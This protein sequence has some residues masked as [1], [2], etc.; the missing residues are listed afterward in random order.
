M[1]NARYP[2]VV[3]D[4]FFD[5][6]DKI[7]KLMNQCEFNLDQDM[8]PGVRTDNLQFLD[9]DFYDF[10]KIKLLSI[11]QEDW[12]KIKSYYNV[13]IQFE[14]ITPFKDKYD[15]RNT[16]MVHADCPAEFGG[17]VYLDPDPDPDAGTTLYTKTGEYAKM[18]D[19]MIEEWRKLYTKQDVDIDKFQKLY[20]KLMGYFEESVIVKP[21]FNRLVMFDGTKFHRCHNF[22]SK[23]RYTLV[24]FCGI[25]PHSN[26]LYQPA[27]PLHRVL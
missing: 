27:P 17:V 13:N 8:Y 4:D 15:I 7:R 20:K 24:F 22:G 23:P 18:P 11:F 12:N 2:T 14:K 16:G 1:T 3:I 26:T 5:N 6:P 25:A 9:S 19:G 10:I 21:K